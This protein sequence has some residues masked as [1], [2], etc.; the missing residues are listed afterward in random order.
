MKK[1]LITVRDLKRFLDHCDNDSYLQFEFEGEEV[2][3]WELWTTEGKPVISFRR[4][5][6]GLLN[7]K[8]EKE[9]TPK[10]F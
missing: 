4:I 9:K 6:Q 5:V 10:S 2:S 1:H 3:P 7:T 8:V